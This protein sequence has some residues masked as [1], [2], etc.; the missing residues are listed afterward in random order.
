VAPSAPSWPQ[1]IPSRSTRGW[2]P[3]PRAARNPTTERAQLQPARTPLEAI[4]RSAQAAGPRPVVVV[5]AVP[6]RLAEAAAPWAQRLKA[7][8]RRVPE[9]PALRPSWAL[10]A[11]EPAA[12]RRAPEAAGVASK[13]A[14]AAA[15]RPTSARRAGVRPGGLPTSARQAV[16]VKAGPRRQEQP[17]PEQVRRPGRPV[18]QVALPA[19]PSSVRL[20]G[21]P[22]RLRRQGSVRARRQ[23]VPRWLRFQR[24]ETQRL[25]AAATEVARA[26]RSVRACDACG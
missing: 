21:E 23:A 13:V 20:R 12:L 7:R 5:V 10:P 15:A 4:P 6:A 8:P 18:R 26:A 16:A 14:A 24:D 1:A 22:P 3:A 25:S 9:A 19:R 11:A 2:A 17:R